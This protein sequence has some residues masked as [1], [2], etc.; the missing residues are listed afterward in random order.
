MSDRLKCYGGPLH[1]QQVAYDGLQLL[2]PIHKS[3]LFTIATDKETVQ[4]EIVYVTYERKTMYIRGSIDLK[5]LLLDC[6]YLEGSI[7][8]QFWCCG[9]LNSWILMCTPTQEICYN[10]RC[11][12]CKSTRHTY[13]YLLAKELSNGL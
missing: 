9:C 6:W 5:P 10:G 13:D 12:V 4:H 7:P 2:V 8:L 3:P 11:E 1:G